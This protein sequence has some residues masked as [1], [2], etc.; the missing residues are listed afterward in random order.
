M[1]YIMYAA[2]NKGQQT[3]DVTV[4]GGLTT[5]H[6]PCSSPFHTL[7]ICKGIRKVREETGLT[8]TYLYLPVGET[9]RSICA[10]PVSFAVDCQRQSSV[11]FRLSRDAMHTSGNGTVHP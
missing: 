1:Q 2:R 3:I 6:N 10:T 4:S 11:T 9:L 8:G 5:S 7:D